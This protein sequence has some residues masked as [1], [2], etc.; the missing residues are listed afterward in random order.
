MSNPYQDIIHLPRPRPRHHP[1]LTAWQ[2]SA[3][4]SPFAA[5][6]GFDGVVAEVG[7]LTDSQVILGEDALLALNEQLSCLNR[8]L[9]ERPRISVT[10]FCPDQRKAGGSYLTTIGRLKKLDDISQT[11][12]LQTGEQIPLEQVLWVEDRE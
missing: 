7:R 5:L 6:T 4:F 1:E 11:M 9:G 8:R 3:Q 12:I 10:W 2:R